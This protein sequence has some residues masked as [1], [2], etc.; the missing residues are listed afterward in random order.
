M[1]GVPYISELLKVHEFITIVFRC[2]ASV[3][4]YFMLKHSA[5]KIIGDSNV[6]YGMVLI[7]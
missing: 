6:K 2:E 4:F 7:G 1:N 3:K 5:R